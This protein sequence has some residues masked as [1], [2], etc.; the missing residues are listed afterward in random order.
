MPIN[1]GQLSNSLDR[2]L[3]RIDSSLSSQALKSN[4]PLLGQSTN[5]PPNQ[6]LGRMRSSLKT[7]LGELTSSYAPG[8]AN[9]S[10]IQPK[11]FEILGNGPGGLGILKDLTGD[12]KVDVSDVQT[13]NETYFV[14]SGGGYGSDVGYGYG[15]FINF[16]MKVGETTARFNQTL[17]TQNLGLS[18]LGFNLNGNAAFQADSELLLDFGF[19]LD[20][21]DYYNKPGY[22]ARG[23]FYAN[24]GNSQEFRVNFK[25]L[26]FQPSSGKLGPLPI[27]ASNAGTGIS[28]NFA[29]DFKDSSD[30]GTQLKDSE[31]Q[32]LSDANFAT[33]SLTGNS[34]IKLNLST[35]LPTGGLLP[36]IKSQLQI[37]WSLN[38]AKLDP[39][40]PATLG[41]VPSVSFNNVQLD[42]ATF[43]GNFLSPILQK[44]NDVTSPVR[45]VTDE[46]TKPIA[47]LSKLLK[48]D[49]TLFDI[50]EIIGKVN[51]DYKMD[52]SFVK[53][54]ANLISLA[55]KLPN[56][57]DVNLN[58]GS[59]ALTGVDVRSP[60]FKLSNFN[61]VGGSL[62][63]SGG[64]SGAVKSFVDSLQNGGAGIGN[65]SLPILT[66]P[67]EAY[68]LLFGNP[69]VNLFDYKMPTLSVCESDGRANYSNH[70]ASRCSA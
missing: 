51:P 18:S 4:V 5:L 1:V 6:L 34:N 10:D 66:D 36:T 54:T 12:G 60:S 11:L 28:A 44:V 40:Q 43:M 69:N 21:T 48:R 68:K 39:T 7:R 59:L 27:T 61:P 16:K 20:P 30:E 9:E 52:L 33:A 17:T 38:T 41:G 24:T 15:G 50:A 46:L 26:D 67:S 56:A 42:M 63:Y 57:N 37:D 29:I 62:F 32:G 8:T 22:T 3:G 14:R 35:N 45:S 53:A 47:P 19:E 58:F 31:L 55:G 25:L 2:Y 65:F 23:S 49:V 70:W 64:S 13:E